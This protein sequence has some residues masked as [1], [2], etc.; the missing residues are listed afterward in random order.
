MKF[1]G[2][3]WNTGSEKQGVRSRYEC[4]VCKRKYKMLWAKE[5]HENLCKNRK[6]IE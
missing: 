6:R 3:S 5:N 2:Y 4:S 1:G